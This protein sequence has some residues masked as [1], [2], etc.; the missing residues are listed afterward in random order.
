MKYHRLS[1]LYVPLALWYPC[2]RAW[3]E[4]YVILKQKPACILEAGSKRL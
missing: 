3:P 1:C 4:L 2:S